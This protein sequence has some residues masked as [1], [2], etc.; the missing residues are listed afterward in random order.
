MARKNAAQKQAQREKLDQLARENP[1]EHT[2]LEQEQE[3]G[4]GGAQ[5]SKKQMNRKDKPWDVD[6]TEHWKVEPWQEADMQG[7]LLEESSFATVSLPIGAC[8]GSS[9]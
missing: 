2:R 8:G 5:K 3:Q 6:G 1:E 4:Q 7:P 9:R